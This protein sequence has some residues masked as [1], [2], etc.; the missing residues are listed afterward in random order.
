ME[1]LGERNGDDCRGGVGEGVG[2]TEGGRGGR[3]RLNSSLVVGSGGELR[4]D[5]FECSDPL[6][7]N[8]LDCEGAGVYDEAERSLVRRFELFASLLS[9]KRSE[10]AGVA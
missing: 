2:C 9:S 5:R 1:D 10:W 7:L 3:S 8:S 6:L 4:E